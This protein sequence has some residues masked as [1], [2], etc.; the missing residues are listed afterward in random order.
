MDLGGGCQLAQERSVQD[1]FCES[2]CSEGIVQ[3][4]LMLKSMDFRTLQHLIKL[5]QDYSVIQ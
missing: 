1:Q 4:L 2:D 3:Y 5:L